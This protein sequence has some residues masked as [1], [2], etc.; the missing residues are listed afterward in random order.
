MMQVVE[1]QPKNTSVDDINPIDLKGAYPNPVIGDLQNIN[2]DLPEFLH[3]KDIK[4]EVFDMSGKRLYENNVV[5]QPQNQLSVDV[6]T[7]TKGSYFYKVSSGNYNN[8][9]KFIILK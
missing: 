7:Y 6:S 3:D 2:F 4:V 9:N 5:G 8:T 1:I